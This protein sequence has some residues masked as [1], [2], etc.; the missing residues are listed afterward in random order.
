MFDR[1]RSDYMRGESLLR[2]TRTGSHIIILTSRRLVVLNVQDA[3][4]KEIRLQDIVGSEVVGSGL[5]NK[6]RLV[7]MES[8]DRM[9]RHQIEVDDARVWNNA[10]KEG[11]RTA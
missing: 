1:I 10:L 11:V 7:V 5:F 3:G 4:S 8:K 2:F 6:R 9:I